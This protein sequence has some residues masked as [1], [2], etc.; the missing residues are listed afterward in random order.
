MLL[1]GEP[2]RLLP[3][4]FLTS[5]FLDRPRDDFEVYYCICK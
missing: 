2:E 5:E 3:Q 4:L 1:R